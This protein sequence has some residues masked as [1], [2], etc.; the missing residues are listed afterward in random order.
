MRC[1]RHGCSDRKWMRGGVNSGEA[2]ILL[3]QRIDYVEDRDVNNGHGAAGAAGAE[4]FAKGAMFAR[5]NRRMVQAGGVYGDL[6]PVVDGI[7][8][9]FLGIGSELGLG[10]KQGAVCL[11]KRAAR[12]SS[13][14]GG[15]SDE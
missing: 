10:M 13:K 8:R 12:A 14:S 6:I 5:R 7:L 1:L 4:L 2:L 3:V 15:G 9:Q 11:G